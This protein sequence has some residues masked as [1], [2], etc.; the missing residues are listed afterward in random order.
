MQKVTLPERPNWRE[1]AEEV[2]F[3]FADM[4]GEPYWDESSAYQFSLAE[5]ENDIEDPSTELHAMC[6][7]AVEHILSSDALIARMG[8]PEAYHDLVADSWRRNEPEIYGRFDLA[9]DGNGPAKL[10][11]YNADTPTSLYESA[12]FQWQWLEDQLAA[13]VLPGGADQFNGI[14]EA[15]IER[16]R[17]L[18]DPNTDLHFTA[19]GGNTEDYA[20]VE[21]MGWAAREAGMGAH[22][23]DLEKIGVTKDGQFVD[24]QDRIIGTLFKLYPW[25]DLLREDYARHIAGSGALFLEPAWKALV[26]NKGLLPVLWQM[27]EGHPNLLPA[28]FA[29]DVA[30]AL[31]AGQKPVP[32]VAASFDRAADAIRAGHVVKPL[33]SREGASISIVENGDVT[34]TSPNNDYDDHPKIVQALATLPDFDGFHPIIGSWVVGGTCVGM[35]LREDR[36][37][38]TQDLSR[39]KPHFIID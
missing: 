38:I 21:A 9:Y 17:G 7:E 28:F 18:F 33:F 5:V 13:G 14:H 4:H 12:S 27:F 11:E 36:A 26:S 25:E 15:L 19:I 37:R 35:G 3:T 10:L 34:E 20:T 29:D 39:F 2:G 23:T 32:A 8:I 16:F 24:D 1:T 30:D 6:R 31:V 22:Y